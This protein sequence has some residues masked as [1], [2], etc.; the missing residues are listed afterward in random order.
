MIRK[1]GMQ[2]AFEYW[3]NSKFP[4]RMSQGAKNAFDFGEPDTVGLH[5]K[6]VDFNFGVPTNPA[7][8]FGRYL[9]KHEDGYV[10]L[11]QS[12][13]ENEKTAVEI[14]D[15]LEELKSSWKLD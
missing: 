9:G 4:K 6:R 8:P 7:G 3:E 2:I 15:T 1:D 10:V 14:F 11:V 13:W 5:L 12:M